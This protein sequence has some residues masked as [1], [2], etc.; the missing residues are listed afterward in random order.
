[1]TEINAAK[2][3]CIEEDL[4]SSISTAKEIFFEG[5]VFVYPT[6]TIYGFGAN[7]FNND[8][9][10]K[11][12]DIK[13]RKNYK[14]FILLVD[15]I[16]T[17]SQYVELYSEKHLDFLLA[18]WPDAVSVVLKLNTK[19]SSILDSETAAFRIPNHRFCQKLTAELQMPIISTSVNRSGSAPL[20]H[21]EEIKNEFYSEVSAIFY[22]NKKSFEKASTLINL[23][24]SE[25]ELLRE[26]RIKFNELMNKFNSFL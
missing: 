13:G 8:A 11:I 2:Y 25:P 18:I 23:T 16:N 7:P 20:M 5:G 4:E 1:M 3:I 22:S 12:N 14:N 21:P 17:I 24:G 10:K 15:S 19:I 9:V 6:D 26:G